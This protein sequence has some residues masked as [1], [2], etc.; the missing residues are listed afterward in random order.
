MQD[1]GNFK[2][3]NKNNEDEQFHWIQQIVTLQKNHDN[4]Q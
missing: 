3:F 1:N 4:K 2:D